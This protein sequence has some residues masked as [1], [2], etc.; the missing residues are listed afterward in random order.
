MNTELNK[1]LV[2]ADKVVVSTMR[3]LTNSK[4]DINKYTMNQMTGIGSIVANIRTRDGLWWKVGHSKPE[5]INALYTN[6][7]AIANKL[8]EVSEGKSQYLSDIHIFLVGTALI[9][10]SFIEDKDAVKV[11]RKLVAS[12]L[13]TAANKFGGDQSIL[14]LFEAAINGKVPARIWYESITALTYENTIDLEG[15]LNGSSN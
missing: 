2:T 7:N 14:Y 9:A 12:H 8:E 11:Q 15:D 1:K 10:E 5:K 3:K 6:L 13:E 4:F